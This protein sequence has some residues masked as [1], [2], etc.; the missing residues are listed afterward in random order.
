MQHGESGFPQSKDLSFPLNYPRNQNRV[1]E[2]VAMDQ[3]AASVSSQNSSNRKSLSL[4]QI[5]LLNAVVCGVE[6]CACSGFTYIPPMLLKAG[7]TEENMSIILGIGPL[8][9]F[10]FVPIIGRASDRCRSQYG[11]R[12]PFILM[13]SVLIIISLLVIPYGEYFS[14]LFLGYTPTSKTVALVILTLSV[15]LL[16]FTSQAC[17]TPCEALLSDA[18]KGT[19]QKDRVFM[20]YS[21]MV[22][23]GGLLGYLITAIDWSNTFI[24]SYFGTQ[25]RS[26]FSILIVLFLFLLSATIMVAQEH[27]LSVVEDSEMENLMTKEDSGNVTVA[28]GNGGAFE[29]GYESSGSEDGGQTPASFS[30]G[31]K[32]RHRKAFKQKSL[33]FRGICGVCNL[34]TLVVRVRIFSCFYNIWTFIWSSIYNRL[35]D[36]LR[37]VFDVPLVLQKL[38]LAN[39]CSW[40][41]V[42][43]FNL[44]FTDFV[45]QAVFQG[46]P[47]APE[48]SYLRHRYD[49]GVRMGSWGLLFHCITSTTYVFFIEGLVEKY[50]M[51]NTYLAGM[52]VFSLSMF[53]M[54]F[55]RHIIFVNMMASLTG[56][57]YAT[58]TTIPFILI[59]KYHNNKEVSH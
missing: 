33:A 23:L 46:N 22:S 21:Q 19:N 31:R 51:R 8:L 48:N 20:V 29:S 3:P 43:G 52:F 25:E 32:G 4:M 42:M 7:Y 41:A 38:A 40:T 45:G 27:P 6:V 53:G 2:T 9:G 44:F 14:N 59:T 17:L 34:L 36:S 54:V 56:F 28:I 13:L 30:P 26:V 18:A 1:S 39:F 12:R 47:N 16:D 58:L 5:F 50:G 57:A 15:I 35:P 10:I 49:E 24:G 37:R 55:Y 11:R